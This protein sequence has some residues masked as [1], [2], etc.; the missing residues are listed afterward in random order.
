MNPSYQEFLSSS[1]ARFLQQHSAQYL[2]AG[3][4]RLQRYATT[5]LMQRFGIPQSNAETLVDRA[6]VK[7]DAYYIDC[8]E[9]TS[10]RLVIRQAN[11][12]RIDVPIEAVL[13]ALKLYP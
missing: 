1:A 11:S 9:S 13:K 5:H 8:S 12:H 4:P 2:T 7:P 10:T 3:D 6:D